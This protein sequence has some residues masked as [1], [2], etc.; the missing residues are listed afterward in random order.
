MKRKFTPSLV[1]V[2]SL[3]L[4]ISTAMLAEEDNGSSEPGGLEKAYKYVNEIQAGMKNLSNDMKGF[5]QANSEKT[6]AKENEQ[7]EKL[8]EQAEKYED[9]PMDIMSKAL[10]TKLHGIKSSSSFV[11]SFQSMAVD[12]AVRSDKIATIW[13]EFL[14]EY[15]QITEKLAREMMLFTDEEMNQG[16]SGK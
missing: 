8:L 14:F 15:K 2:L 16:E 1:F 3:T 10:Q 13:Y 12:V 7:I 6:F 9:S 4:L 5:S 11:Q